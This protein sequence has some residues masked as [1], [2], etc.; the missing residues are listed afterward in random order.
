M[1]QL[2]TS[3]QASLIVPVPGNPDYSAI[4]SNQC[5]SSIVQFYV[6]TEDCNCDLF[7]PNVF[8]PDGEGHNDIFR[9]TTHHL[10]TDGAITIINRWGKEVFHSASLNNGWDGTDSGKEMDTGVYFWMIQ[11][12]CGE[13][14]KLQ[15]GYVQLIR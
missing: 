11:Y 4:I 10:V 6:S 8:T 12:G 14:R 1:N 13:S 2:I 7:V 9:P 3:T 5:Y 15:T